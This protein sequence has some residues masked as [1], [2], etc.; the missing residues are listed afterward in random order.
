MFVW[1]LVFPL[2]AIF[3]LNIGTVC[4][5]RMSCLLFYYVHFVIFYKQVMDKDSDDNP[6]KYTNVSSTLHILRR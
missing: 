6:I 3:R 1:N 2:S 5:V 4:T